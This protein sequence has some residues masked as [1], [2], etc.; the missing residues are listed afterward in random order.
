RA[1]SS[2]L[3]RLGETL[4][5]HA[6]RILLDVTA[7]HRELSADLRAAVGLEPVLRPPARRDPGA[8]EPPSRA[9]PARPYR[10]ASGP[11]SP[12][13]DDIEVPPWVERQP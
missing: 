13:A 6:E 4:E 8:V 9:R 2:G 11:S 10:Q 5:A 7:G 12:G 3:R 1:V